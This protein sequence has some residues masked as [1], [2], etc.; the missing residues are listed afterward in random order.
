[1]EIAAIATISAANTAYVEPLARPG[2]SISQTAATEGSRRAIART[3]VVR[4]DGEVIKRLRDTK[5]G[6]RWAKGRF[7]P[8][9]LVRLA[10]G[11]RR[12]A[13][14]RTFRLPRMARLVAR[15]RRYPLPGRVEHDK[16]G[17]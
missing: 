11:A 13:Q 3:K 12:E 2:F 16:L 1:M 10:A 8:T 15:S 4:A 17:Q 6:R 9:A 5:G 14:E 7:R